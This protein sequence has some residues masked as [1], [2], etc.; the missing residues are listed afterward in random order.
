MPPAG[1][2]A[3]D[4][5]LLIEVQFYKKIEV[6]VLLRGASF[7]GSL[8]QNTSVPVAT[9]TRASYRSL[10]LETIDLRLPFTH[11][12][13]HES[14]PLPRRYVHDGALLAV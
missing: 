7:L 11:T 13:I 5:G 6:T 9:R 10:M 4:P 12:H 3:L 8:Q 14:I 2:E 1:A